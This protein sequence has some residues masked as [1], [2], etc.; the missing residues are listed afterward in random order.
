MMRFLIPVLVLLLSWTAPSMAEPVGGIAMHGA[1]KYPDGFAHFDYVNPDAPKG[2]EVRRHALGGFDNLNPF[3]VKGQPAGPGLIP[4]ETL[5]KPSADEP[6]SEYG[7]IA[8]TIETPSD[9][10]WVVF[11]LR[12][13]AR[14]HDGSPILADDVLF[15]FE[16][17]KTQGHPFYRAYYHSVAKAEKLGD[18]KVRFSFVPGENRE[19]PLILGQMPVLSKAYWQD[20]PFDQT[21]LEPPLGSGPYRIEKVEPNRSITL[22]RV[23]DYWG[24]NLAVNRGLNN[25][26]RLI[27]DYYRDSTV[28]LEAFKAGRYDIRSENEARKWATG[29]DFP[30]VKDGRVKK[31][32]FPNKRPTGM[33]GY[34]YNLRRPIWQDARVRRALA[35]AFDF[36]W[37]NKNLFHGQYTRTKSYFSN[38][39]LASSGLPSAGELKFLEPLRG[40]IPDEVFTTVYDVPRTDGPDGVRGNLRIAAKLLEEAGYVIKDGVLVDGATGK[41]FTFEILLDQPIWER[42]SLPFVNNLKRLGITATVRTVDSAQYEERMKTYDYDMLVAVW[43]QSETPGNEQRS[44]WG[45]EA[46]DLPGGR[47]LIGIKD[48]AVDS[49][50]DS[51]V[52]APDRQSLV[53]RTRALDRV[54]LWNHY[55]IPHW[56]MIVDRVAYW[57]KF[58]MPDTVPSQG[59]QFNSWWAKDAAAQ[60]APRN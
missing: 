22:A 14:F 10:S 26:D 45:S 1:V 4:F 19:L 41:P 54:L 52:A 8:E 36:E 12:P 30:A 59:V 32:A 15:S 42:V 17:L 6:F 46:A 2:G 23:P 29:Y 31:S 43:G 18:R 7:L 20:R 56:H 27:Y 39:D 24:Q 55:V 50:I 37:T 57:D 33:Q 35:Y 38:S 60:P 48:K 5:M 25:F 51:L 44:Y 9:R 47:N 58:G 11:T 21:T 13:E 49:L 40:A 3:I 28:A 16:T 34:V 53:D